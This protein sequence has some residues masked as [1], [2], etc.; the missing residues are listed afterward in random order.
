MK[1]TAAD[2]SAAGKRKLVGKC[3]LKWR[4][5]HA[6]TFTTCGGLGHDGIGA[7]VASPRRAMGVQ[8]VTAFSARSGE[9][10]ARGTA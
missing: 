9:V 2:K 6:Q 8:C 5:G 10:L 1:P 7:F 4:L 3:R